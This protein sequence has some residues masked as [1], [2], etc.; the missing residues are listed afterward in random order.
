M[1]ELDP[2]LHAFAFQHLTLAA[3]GGERIVQDSLADAQPQQVNL[4]EGILVKNIISVLG[5]GMAGRSAERM[6]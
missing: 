2:R 6:G 3:A 5:R 4:V 1:A